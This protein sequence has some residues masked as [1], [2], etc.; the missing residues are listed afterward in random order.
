[1]LNLLSLPL[2]LPKWTI[3]LHEVWMTNIW[4]NSVCQAASTNL[5][6]FKRFSSCGTS[7]FLFFFLFNKYSKMR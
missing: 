5:K 1:M 3:R 6:I 4:F 7:Y 2:P